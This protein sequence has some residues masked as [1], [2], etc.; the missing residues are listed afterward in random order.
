MINIHTLYILTGQFTEILFKGKKKIQN[1]PQKKPKTKQTNIVVA[2]FDDKTFNI[3]SLY[4]PTIKKT[5]LH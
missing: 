5:Q 4:V 1:P 2:E 3:R